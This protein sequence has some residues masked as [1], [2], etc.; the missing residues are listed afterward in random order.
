[1]IKSGMSAFFKRA[2]E[3]SEDAT[4]TNE[5]KIREEAAARRALREAQVKENPCQDR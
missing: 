5:Q 2:I 1:M 4:K 3:S